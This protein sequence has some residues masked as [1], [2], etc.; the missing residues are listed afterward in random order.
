MPTGTQGTDARKF[1]WQAVHYMRKGIAYDTTGIGSTGTVKVGTLPSGAIVEKVQVKV[2]EVFDAGTTNPLDVGTS[3]DEDCLVDSTASDVDLT[4]TGS[5]FVLRGSD[6]T[7]SADTA[8][9]VT[10]AQTGTAATQGAAEVII[11]YTVD[12]DQ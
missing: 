5:T 1:P 6:E 8:I 9:Y 12:N 3:S 10:Y 4:A 11:F 2:T 7:F